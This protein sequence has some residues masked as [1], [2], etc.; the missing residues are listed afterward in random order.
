[1]QRQTLRSPCSCPGL[2]HS[3]SHEGVAAL[4]VARVST[5][6]QPSP[7][8]ALSVHG[9]QIWGATGSE[10]ATTF[11]DS[12]K[13]PI[14][15]RGSL[16]FAMSLAG[17]ALVTCRHTATRRLANLTSGRVLSHSKQENA[18][19]PNA[20]HS[21]TGNNS[22]SECGVVSPR[23]ANVDTFRSARLPLKATLHS[24]DTTPRPRR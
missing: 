5:A 6:P 14:I 20:H 2:L 9:S 18:Y 13:A 11:A 21:G 10:P 7:W 1:M 8:F 17:G 15:S 22:H 4:P 23:E 19:T 24:F 3:D 16:L 12:S